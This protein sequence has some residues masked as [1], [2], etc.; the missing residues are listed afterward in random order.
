MKAMKSVRSGWALGMT[1][2]VAALTGCGA[3]IEGSGRIVGE[4]REVPEF[5]SIELSDGISA[6]VLVGFDQGL[7]VAGDDNLVP[8]VKTEVRNGRLQ[9]FLP[10]SVESWSTEND[11]WVE[12]AV[13]RLESLTRSAGSAVKV[14]GLDED[15]F[16]LDASGGGHVELTG[17]A[18]TVTAEL[19]GGTQLL[20]RD[21]AAT[22]ATLRSSGGGSTVMQVSTTLSVEASGGGDVRIIGQPTV[23]TQDLSGGSTLTFE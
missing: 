13:P 10:D 9:V 22:D 5:T 16:T 20:A 1:L 12:V 4:T 19:S 18:A 17:R 6:N 23:R 11:L 7:R 15:I 2:L 14:S 21:F 8:L 3:Q